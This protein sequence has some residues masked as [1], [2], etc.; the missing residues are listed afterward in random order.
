MMNFVVL[1]VIR[2]STIDAAVKIIL[3]HFV[4]AFFLQ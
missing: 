1:R 4:L 3:I 2:L